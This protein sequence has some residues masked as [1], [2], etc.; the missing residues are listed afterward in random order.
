[1]AQ[2]EQKGK[3]ILNTLLVVMIGQVG[4]LTLIVILA[5]VFLGLWLD[6][7]FGTKPTFTLILLIAG[8]PLSVLLML[9][10]SRRTLAK[11]QET[12]NKEKE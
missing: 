2:S 5:S 12:N 9:T 1:M 8:I 3:Q 7:Q 10:V 4:C 6:G 11:L